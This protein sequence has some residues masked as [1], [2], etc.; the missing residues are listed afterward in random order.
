MYKSGFYVM[1]VA[2]IG[3]FAHVMFQMNMEHE[4]KIQAQF[5]GQEITG[6]DYTENHVVV[7]TRDRVFLFGYHTDNSWDEGIKIE[8]IFMGKDRERLW[9]EITHVDHTSEETRIFTKDG[10]VL[11]ITGELETVV[12]R[13]GEEPVPCTK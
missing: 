9:M 7:R 8:E 13:P 2:I 12:E 11:V 3:F 10:G 5:L 1:A 6:F 4:A